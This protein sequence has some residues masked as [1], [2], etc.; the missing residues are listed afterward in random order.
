MVAK[1]KPP[2]LKRDC[3]VT[4][5]MTAKERA[6]LVNR[7]KRQYFVSLTEFVRHRLGLENP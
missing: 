7:T 6:G 4:I 2:G 1:R 5:R 3:F